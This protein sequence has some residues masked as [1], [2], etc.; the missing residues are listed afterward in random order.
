QPPPPGAPKPPP[1]KAYSGGVCPTLVAGDNAF[2]SMGNMREV[3][4]AV[5]A[6]LQ[7]NEVLPV[8]FLWHWL[9]GSPQDFYDKGEV[10]TAVDTQRFLAVL[11]KS[12][13]DL[14]FEW[15]FSIV[16]SQARMDEELA[17]FDDLQSCVSEQ[18]NVNASCVSSVGVSA[19]A[20]F[21]D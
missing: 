13:G 17:F 1:P 11:P 4:V 19:G 3:K 5:P 16:D 20:L 14:L 2:L 12:K 7:P 9:K 8:I 18:F 10:Q 15:T 21:T 6:N